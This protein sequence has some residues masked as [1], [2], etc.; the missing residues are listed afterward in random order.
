MQK[1]ITLLPDAMIVIGGVLLSYGAGLLHPATGFIVG[2]VL[3]LA[4]GVVAAR[5]AE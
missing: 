2:G 3:M 5:K 4:F 1:I